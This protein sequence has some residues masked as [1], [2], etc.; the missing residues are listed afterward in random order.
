[1]SLLIIILNF[2]F[3]IIKCLNEKLR[4]KNSAEEEIRNIFKTLTKNILQYVHQTVS[5]YT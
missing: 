5:R 3:Y 1:M 4:K 2:I